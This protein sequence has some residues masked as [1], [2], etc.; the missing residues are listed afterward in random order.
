MTARIA[1]LVASRL[2]VPSV[3]C[4][5][6]VEDPPRDEEGAPADVACAPEVDEALWA[7]AAAGFSGTVALSTGGELD[8]EAAYGLAGGRE[9]L[10]W[11]ALDEAGGIAAVEISDDPPTLVVA[12]AG[13]GTYRPADP[14][15]GGP[16]VTLVFAAEELTVTG[17][18]STVT[19]RRL[20]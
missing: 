9:T 7:W 6:N 1:L 19:A 13:S 11:Y 20:P 15:G 5:Q 10:V 3:A 17:P 16:A 14:T 8:C 18:D 12:P 4:S 2:L